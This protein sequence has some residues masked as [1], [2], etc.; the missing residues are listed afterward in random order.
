MA[1]S[2]QHTEFRYVNEFWK[3][4]KQTTL[5]KTQQSDLEGQ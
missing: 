4:N 1:I 2:I 3:T 5:I